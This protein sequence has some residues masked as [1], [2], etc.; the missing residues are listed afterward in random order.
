M[1]LSMSVKND[2]IS[3][4]KKSDTDNGSAEVQIALLTQRIRDLTEHMKEHKHDFHSNRGLM[5]LVGRRRRLMRYLQNE[6][7]AKYRELIQSLEIR[8]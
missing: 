3:Q 6:D 2:I 8:G 1:P 7:L 4:Y 5:K